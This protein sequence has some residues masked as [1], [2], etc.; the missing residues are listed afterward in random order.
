MYIL[1]KLQSASQAS[2]LH[3]FKRAKTVL[4]HAQEAGLSQT[5]FY[6]TDKVQLKAENDKALLSRSSHLY[7]GRVVPSAVGW[8]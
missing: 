3:V 7:L 2:A 1:W 8:Y 6:T 5:D 4:R